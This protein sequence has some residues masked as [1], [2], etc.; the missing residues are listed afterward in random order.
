MPWS[1]KLPAPIALDDGQVFTTLRDA[2]DFAVT[3]S[4]RQKAHLAWQYAIEL[5]MKAA[6]ADA[7]ED[8]LKGG[9]ASAL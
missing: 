6:E 7:S 5:M 8:D 1:R 4:N 2:A 3:I 9:R